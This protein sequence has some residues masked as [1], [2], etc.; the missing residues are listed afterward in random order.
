M[1]EIERTPAALLFK[2]ADD[3]N[4]NKAQPFF[5]FGNDPSHK[6]DL[7]S[8]SPAVVLREATK[9]YFKG[10]PALSPKLNFSPFDKKAHEIKYDV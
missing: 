2:K 7:P 3:P 4:F 1:P 6:A 10:L 8:L 5:P 9:P